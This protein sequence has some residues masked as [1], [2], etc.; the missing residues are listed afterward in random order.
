[1]DGLPRLA[2]ALG[3]V[4]VVMDR[5]ISGVGREGETVTITSDNIDAYVRTRKGG[6]G[7]DGRAGRQ[8]TFI[9]EALKKLKSEGII[10]LAPALFSEFLSYGKTNLNLDQVVSLA[11]FA[12]KTDLDNLNTYRVPSTGK[13]ISGTDYQ[14]VDMTA[15]EQYVLET[16]YDPDDP[17][18][19]DTLAALTSEEEQ[20][21][22]EAA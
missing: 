7:D 22:E 12:D 16:F 9:T 2:D 3:G 10:N 1:M 14:I 4:E 15:L 5:T 11:S 20:T 13:K 21:Q 17:G 19:A 8:V 18:V 6:G